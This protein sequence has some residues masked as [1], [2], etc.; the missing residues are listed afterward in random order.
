MKN[1]CMTKNNGI[2][3]GI[4]LH[5][6]YNIKEVQINSVANLAK[7]LGGGGEYFVDSFFVLMLCCF[8]ANPS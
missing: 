5:I 2:L 8:D 7:T 1:N 6:Y 4:I 3:G